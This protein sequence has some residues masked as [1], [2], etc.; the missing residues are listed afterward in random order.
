M[1]SRLIND[2]A[3]YE[4]HQNLTSKGYETKWNTFKPCVYKTFGYLRQS[5]ERGETHTYEEVGDEISTDHRRYLSIWLQ[6]INYHEYRVDRPP[7]SV[8]VIT[9]KN[10]IP[11]EG[12]F[13]QM[14][15]LGHYDPSQ[16][17]KRTLSRELQHSVFDFW[18]NY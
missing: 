1:N 14:E 5:A 15:E 9:V 8:L 2:E 18:Q 10:R 4:I 11:S 13:E 6:G 16:D 17:D 7:L 12:F 3:L